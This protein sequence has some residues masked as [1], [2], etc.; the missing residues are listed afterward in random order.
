MTA[1]QMRQPRL[2]EIVASELRQRI[3]SG[4]LGEG[5]HLPRQE[6]LLAEFQV[7]GPSAREALRILETEGLVTVLR[8]NVGGAV[9]HLPTTQQVAYMISL[10]MEAR[11]TRLEEVATA[12]LALEPLC[13][14]LCAEREDRAD[15]V[16]PRLEAVIEDQRE[17]IEDL[18]AFN[19][20]TRTFHELLAELCGNQPLALNLGAL[21]LV[22]SSHETDWAER[23]DST[24]QRPPREIVE[25]GIV[26]HEKLL[27]AIRDGDGE[28]ASR[29]ARAHLEAS[30]NYVMSGLADQRIRSKLLR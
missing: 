24:E 22:W 25:A 13:A 6:D 12:L 26:D 16:V 8:G 27:E 2:A 4:E 29:R 11:G 10:V 17:H 5:D 7:S 14:S 21:E 18:P 15:T 3:L 9:V 1:P 20:A 30:Q 28:R 23:T 19:R